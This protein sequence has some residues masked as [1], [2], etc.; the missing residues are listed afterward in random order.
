MPMPMSS[1]PT[2]LIVDDE[3][4]SRVALQAILGTWGY[5]TDVASDGREALQKAAVLR[6]SLVVTDLMMPGMSGRELSEQLLASDPDIKILYLSGYT[7]DAVV[8]QGVLEPGTS[9]LQ[10][11]FTLQALARKVREV[12]RSERG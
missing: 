3:E 10:K 11:P 5:A 4:D 12:L 1:K 9:F 2:I 8:H 6:P 7:E